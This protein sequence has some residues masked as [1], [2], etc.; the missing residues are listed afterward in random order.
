MSRFD[1][2][3][4]RVDA[5][6]TIRLGEPFTVTPA[7]SKAIEANGV[8]DRDLARFGEYGEV[9]GKVSMV[10]FPA[11]VLKLNQGDRIENESGEA[12]LIEKEEENDGLMV[13]YSLRR[14]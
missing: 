6:V 5:R 9:T 3:V 1:R 7:G 8:L 12:W 10:S 14:V 2:L 4:A 13:K 11:E